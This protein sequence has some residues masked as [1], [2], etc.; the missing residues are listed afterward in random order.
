MTI[1]I[2][3]DG[4]PMGTRVLSPDGTEIKGVQSINWSIQASDGLGVAT[5]TF[6]EAEMAVVT[7]VRRPLLIVYEMHGKKFVRK[8]DYDALAEKARAAGLL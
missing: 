1:K 4:T 6:I 8:E 7:E 2:E 5:I 3:S